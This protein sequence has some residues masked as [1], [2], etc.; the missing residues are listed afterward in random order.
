MGKI[1]IIIKRYENK[2][3]MHSIQIYESADNNSFSL[4][5]PGIIAE[6]SIEERPKITVRTQPPEDKI[7]RELGIYQGKQHGRRWMLFGE[8]DHNKTEL[9]FV[10]LPIYRPLFILNGS[11]VSVKNNSFIVL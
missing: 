5:I 9:E 11:C 2:M 10:L 3:R 4:S 6:M 7:D 1:T 8:Y